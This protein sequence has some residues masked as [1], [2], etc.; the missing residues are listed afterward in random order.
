[1]NG[2]VVKNLR[3][4]FFTL[5]RGRVRALETIDLTVEPGAFFV[6]VGPSG[7][8]KSTLLNIIAGIENPSA[9]EIWIGE[10]Q[11][12]SVAAKKFL[13][14]RRRDVAMVFQSYALYP[15]MTVFANIAFPL[16]IAGTDRRDIETR[17]RAAAAT[18]E[19][20]DLLDARPA[21]LSGGQRQ[22]V[23][24]GRA[25]VRKPTVLLLDEPL[26][27]LDAL[28]R[29]SMRGELKQIQRRLAVTTIYV[30]HDQTEAM[31]LGD[32]IAVLKDGRLQQ[33]G[34]P[35]DIYHRPANSFVAGFI[36][37]LPMN[38]LDGGLL[39]KAQRPIEPAGIEDTAR[40]QLGLRPEQIRITAAA[41][42]IWRARLD[43]ITS[44]GSEAL[45]YLDLDGR[46]IL[47]KTAAPQGLQEQQLVGIDFDAT[48]LYLF[49]RNDGR[50][51][52]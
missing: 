14:P 7:C 5:R 51:I 29:T 23:A 16:K 15:H 10:R 33:T 12:V 39:E 36:G 27:N 44:L 34:T 4:D 18:L 30:T 32:R 35:D 19:I 40:V 26:S 2:I 22:R 21:E 49:D 17:V 41:E 43:L 52:G 38:L 3:K 47:A 48:D 50:R 20:G 24:L 8:G 28:L 25:I 11:V 45:L 13:P 37:M 9:G 1:M 42:G 31:T 6:L 46:Q